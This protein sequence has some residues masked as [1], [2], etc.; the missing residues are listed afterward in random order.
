MRERHQ[1]DIWDIRTGQIHA[2]VFGVFRLKDKN[3]QEI[4]IANR[5]ARAI[6]AMLCMVPDEPLE[7]E[8]I[9]R[10]LWPGRFEAQAKA[11]LR[12]CLT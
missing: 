3:G 10:L 8:F 2:S 11:S 6:L 7:R 1:Q 4:T 5:R 12:Q 9:S